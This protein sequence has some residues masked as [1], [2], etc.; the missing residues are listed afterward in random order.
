MK[1]SP[2]CSYAEYRNVIRDKKLVNNIFLPNEVKKY[3]SQ[4]RLFCFATGSQL[5]LLYDEVDYYQLVCGIMEGNDMGPFIDFDLSKPIVCHIVVNNKSNVNPVVIKTLQNSGFRLRCKIHEHIRESL[6]ELPVVSGEVCMT[7]NEIKD[8]SECQNI[9]SL[10]REHLPLYE[11]IYM[12]PEDIQALSDKKQVLFLKDSVTG[13]IAGAC[14]YDIFLGMTTIHHIVVDSCYR[15]KG[16]A[17]ILLSAWL[18]Q[19]KLCGAKVARSWI[20]DTN[21]SSQK[22]FAKVGFNKTENVSY[23]FVK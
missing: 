14:Y 22:S 18:E 17:G 20:E 19:A 13:K 12:L 4:K 10:W 6:A 8:S 9:L 3:I 11:V 16:F 7:C 5:F 1:I 21:I 15:G 23:Q 2:V